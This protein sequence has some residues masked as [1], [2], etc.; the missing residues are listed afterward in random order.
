[1]LSPFSLIYK[2]QVT[3]QFINPFN[4]F[5]WTLIAVHF[6][7]CLSGRQIPSESRELDLLD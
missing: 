1:M 2:V 6:F 4:A 7:I 3:I 5:L